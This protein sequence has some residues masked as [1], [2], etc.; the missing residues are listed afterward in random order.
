ML[1]GWCWGG[2]GVLL[3]VSHGG[4]PGGYP[5]WI[6]CCW[7]AP[8][9]LLLGFWGAERLVAGSRF[10]YARPPFHLPRDPP[11]DRPHQKERTR[12][13]PLGLSCRQCKEFQFFP[14]SIGFRDGT[15]ADAHVRHAQGTGL[16]TR[17]VRKRPASIPPLIADESMAAWLPRAKA[18]L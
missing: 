18:E 1:L 4:I 16:A 11:G 14:G 13:N 12:D 3:G 7:G 9:V 2:A 15:L 17:A 8:G 5:Y 10:K 6:M